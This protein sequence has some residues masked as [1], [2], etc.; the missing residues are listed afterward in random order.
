[1][2]TFWR[3]PSVSSNLALIL[4]M[5]PRFLGGQTSTAVS[6][7]A[8]PNPSVFGAPVTLKASLTPAGATGRVTFYDGAAMLGVSAVASGEATL[9]TRLLGAGAR[10]LRAHYGGDASDLAANSPAVA[11]TVN[12]VAA[13]GFQAAVNYPAGYFANDVAVAD[14]NSDG[15]MD[16][17][18]CDYN[19]IIIFLGNGDGTFQPGY[20]YRYGASGAMAVGDFNGDGKADLA[21]LDEA[22][23]QVR[24][25]LGNGNGTFLYPATYSVGVDATSLVVADFNGDGNADLAVGNATNGTVSILLGNGDGTLQPAVNY[26]VGAWAGVMAAADFNGDGHT[27]LAVAA[28]GALFILLGNGDGTLQ[29]P[30]SYPISESSWVGPVAVGDFNGDGKLDLVVGTSANG[31]LVYLGKG[32]GSFQPPLTTG[33]Q[34]YSGSLVVGDFNGDGKLDIAV[35]D[36][37]ISLSY[38]GAV[39]VLPGQGD[40]TFQPPVSYRVA[41]QQTYGV[42]IGDFNGDGRTDIAVATSLSDTVGILLGQTAANPTVRAVSVSPSSGTG[43]SPLLSFQFSDTAGSSDLASVSAV[44][45][46][47]GSYDYT[48]G[49]TYNGL[50]N[51]LTLWN[52]DGTLPATGFPPGSGFQQNSWCS[53]DGSASS[54]TQSGDLLTVNLSLGYTWPSV[55][56][57]SVWGEAQSIT[58]TTTGWQQLGAWTIGAPA[59]QV[60]SVTPASGTATQKTLTFVFS[61][62][63][64]ASDI[65]SVWVVVNAT[66][67]FASSCAIT[68]NPSL[69]SVSLANDADTAWLGPQTLGTGGPLANSQCSL[70]VAQSSGVI[71]GNTYTLSLSIAFTSAGTKNIYAEAY[72]A[73]GLGSG[74]QT[75]GTW[76]DGQAPGTIGLATS[77]NPATFGQPVTLTG[78]V[79][80]GA[81]GSLTFYDGATV[82]GASAISS[83]T[84][85]LSTFLLGT[86]NHKIAAYYAGETG[87]PSA[88]SNT[89]VQ[90]V[91]SLPEGQLVAGQTL[92]AGSAPTSVAVGDFN[93]DGIAD[94]AVANQSYN[95]V[96]IFLGRGNGTFQ[97]EVIY[98]TATGPKSVVVGDFNGDGQQDL[99]VATGSG[100]SILLGNGYGT[101]RAA[102]TYPAGVGGASSLA[103]ADFNGDGIADLVAGGFGTNVVLFGLGDGTFPEAFNLDAPAAASV[104]V[105]DFNGDGKA[106]VVMT[107][108]QGGGMFVLLGNGNFTFQ[109]A[110]LY[111]AVGQSASGQSANSLVVADFNGDGIADVAVISSS[112]TPGV[113]ILL[114]R[115]D[116]TFQAAVSYAAGIAPAALAVGDFNGDGFPDLAVTNAN[117]SG[118]GN[119]LN[120]LLGNGDGT[121]RSPVTFPAADSQVSVALGDFN[122]DGLVDVAAP[123]FN[124]RTVGILLGQAPSPCNLNSY[125]AV[126]VAGVETVVREALGLAPAVDD[127]NRDGAVNVVDV[128]IEINAAL[129]LSCL[130]R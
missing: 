44:V 41:T 37:Q 111:P 74:W 35:S 102:N 42:A 105:G 20:S 95:N 48:C 79:T 8:S 28:F 67:T 114:G 61:E 86:G 51:T 66:E 1:M 23:G 125:G 30:F 39:T 47:P 71:S 25:A 124:S 118:A 6:L 29:A 98:S 83:G 50:Q 10:T 58:G 122:G 110:A 7:T 27:D 127:L 115:S 93:G 45:G 101:F 55:W 100:V 121:F 56:T 126:S 96:G 70:N 108:F 77:P 26:T 54:A 90:A 85:S 113:S 75:L 89:V 112:G 129:G 31:I 32:D 21:V 5:L 11:Q 60:V 99:A 46:T 22:N 34:D 73:D 119:T 107:P 3:R 81:T 59:P 65:S 92:T 120:I 38:A 52:L 97:P 106:D 80:A 57:Q 104:A 123:N 64:G 12:S 53:L 72:G 128:Q 116:G 19:D 2:S 117:S 15:K 84:A 82:L 16:L 130:V 14:F 63:A 43:L 36:S 40:G 87:Y 18:V 94:L 76:T 68:V 24:V 13:G 33:S 9:T 62:A 17:A 69:G 88:T 49:V 4:T 109:S 91:D 103:V 78:T